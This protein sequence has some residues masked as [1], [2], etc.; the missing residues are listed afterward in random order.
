MAVLA[1]LGDASANPFEAVARFLPRLAAFIVILVV[2]YLLAK[3][4]QRVVRGVLRRV[5]FDR[6]LDRSGI[7]AALARED[8]DAN[9]LLSRLIFY[10]LMLLVLQ[11]AF[12]VFGPNPISDLL[13]RL[14]AFLPRVV[15]AVAIIVVAAVIARATRDVI[16]TL[17]GGLSYGHLLA[18]AA[19]VLIVGIGVFAALDQ[20]QI[21]QTIVTGVFYALLAIIVGVTVVAVGGGGI[22]PMRERW[23]RGL[24]R[25]DDE[26]VRIRDEARRQREAQEEARRQRRAEE[27]ARLLREAAEEARRRE[28]EEAAAKQEPENVG[29]PPLPA[30]PDEE[31]TT[32]GG[33]PTVQIGVEDTT[34][35][36]RPMDEEDTTTQ[37]ARPTDEQDT[38]TR[39]ARTGDDDDARP[40]PEPS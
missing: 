10:G 36:T 1:Q 31:A 29:L 39:I 18:T 5:G 11:L 32:D 14:I 40:P 15:V 13:F 8:H 30:P 12:G 24:A 16:A 17:I 21:A 34:Q 7:R 28:A 4:L 19:Y 3:A 20:L 35:I 27:E 33:E 25:V 26:T 37:M 2:G 22:A 23:E 9:E 38:T 6:A